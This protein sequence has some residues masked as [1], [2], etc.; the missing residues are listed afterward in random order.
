MRHLWKWH[1]GEDLD[2]ESGLTHLAHAA[3]GCF[4]LIWYT[5][6]RSDLDDRSIDTESK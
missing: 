5:K 3:W 6:H 2:K 1:R 4:T